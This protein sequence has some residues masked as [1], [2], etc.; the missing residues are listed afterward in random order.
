MTSTTGTVRPAPRF[1]LVLRGGRVIDPAQGIDGVLD[2]AI[3]AGAIAAVGPAIGRGQARK[4]IDVRDRL[5]I[6][7]DRHHAH[8]YEHVTGAFGM[9]PTWSVSGPGS[10]RSSTRRRRAPHDPG[11]R[12]FIV[13]PPSARLLISNYLVCD[14]SATY[15]D[16]YGPPA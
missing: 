4:T 1:D 2:V 13:E 11:F 8:V 10:R 16:L 7:H 6:R 9:N 12:K 3:R 5:V 14:W 15:T